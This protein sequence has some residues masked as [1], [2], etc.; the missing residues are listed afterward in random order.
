MGLYQKMG[1]DMTRLYHNGVELARK[2][3]PCIPEKG[4]NG[5]PIRHEIEF[6]LT[7]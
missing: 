2:E 3:K 4:E 6:E 1:F 5:I 7:L